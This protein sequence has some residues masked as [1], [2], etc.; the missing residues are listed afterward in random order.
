MR[1]IRPGPRR[2][3]LAAWIALSATPSAMAAGDDSAVAAAMVDGKI[4][5][6]QRDHWA[7]RPVATVE[8]PAVLDEAWCRNPVDRFVLAK[9]EAKGWK[10]APPAAPRALLRRVYLDLIGLP[11]T[12]A[13][14]SAYLDD[15]SPEALDRVVDDL[16]SRPEYGE[17]WARHWLDLA[18][19]AESNGYERDATKPFAWRYRDYV[20]ASLNADKP[21]DR[22]VVEQLAGD[23]MPDADAESLLAT[24][25]L[26]LGPW[27]DEPADPEQ[28]EFDQLDDLVAATSEA[29]LGLTVACARCHDHKF[30]PISQLDYYRVAAVFRPLVRPRAGRVERSLPVGSPVELRA[31]ADAQRTLA[32]A[33]A[34]S[35]ALRSAGLSAIR[36]GGPTQLLPTPVLVEARRADDEVAAIRRTIPDLPRGYFLVEPA[37]ARPATHLLIRGQAS[38]PGPVVEPGVPAVLCG[39][40]PELDAA[41]ARRS[42]RRL[43]FARWLVDPAHPLTARVMVNR[44][45]QHHMGLGIVRSPSDFGTNGLPPTHPELL[46]WLAGRFVADGWS[47]KK[48]HRLILAS[49]TYRMATAAAEDRQAA[50]PENE[51]LWRRPLSRVDVE[52]LRDS[53]LAIAGRLNPARGGPSVYPP[54][55]T[56]TLAGS[57]D[58]ATVWPLSGTVEAARRSIYVFAKR[59]LAVPMFE[60]FDLC[61]STRSTPARKTTTVAQQALTLLNGS[62]SADASAAF[63]DR[64]AR[65]AGPEP[66]DQ[67]DL[68]YRLALGRPATESELDGLARFFEA[69][70]SEIERAGASA[71][72]SRALALA[73]VARLIFCLNEF[74]YPD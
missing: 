27:D 12:L 28:D 72:E 9:L 17:R 19:Y 31:V 40:Q 23:E 38:R 67:F 66:A 18:R 53:M 61:D 55:P 59:S 35:V 49:N 48:L 16:L 74:V 63:A 69:E 60:V 68:A 62:F 71:D 52:V 10:A 36:L 5:D 25:F 73:R 32:P 20:I 24:G 34:R 46:D 1:P 45:W 56:E 65:E 33:I 13:E 64:L 43:A 11:P 30:E 2:A 70:R 26:R 58:P 51:L 6:E 4:T 41:D 29:F 39:P 50:D 14:Q 54:I 15:P 42:G 21:Y 3:L 44:A 47:L 57:S 22:F 7:F 8:P 37:D